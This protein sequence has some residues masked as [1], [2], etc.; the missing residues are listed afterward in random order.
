MAGW[1]R[2]TPPSAENRKS[3]RDCKT[4]AGTVVVEYTVLFSWVQREHEAKKD[5]EGEG[6]GGGASWGN[7]QCSSKKDAEPCGVRLFTIG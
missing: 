4:H 6:G 5:W 7:V 1:P 3:F 2:T